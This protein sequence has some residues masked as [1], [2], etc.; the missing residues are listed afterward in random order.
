MIA[1]SASVLA[2]DRLRVEYPLANGT[3]FTA[4]ENASL[5]IQPGEIHALVGE[6]GAGKTTIGNTVMGLLETPGRIAAGSIHIDGK[7]FDPVKGSAAGIV[8]GRDVGAIFQDPMTS[9]N[10]L[11][12]IGSQ[13]MEAMRF[14][15]K[16]DRIAAAARALELLESV[17]I[18][19][20]RRR[21]KAY[22][23]QLSGGQRQR[24]VIAAALSCNPKLLVADEPTT[25]LDVS[26]QA[27]ILKLLRDLGDKRG[28]GILLVT[29]NMGVVAQIAD[30]VT[31]MHRGQVVESGA[32]EEVLRR[33]KAPYAR[34]LI[35][36]VPRIDQRLDRFPV[37]G[38]EGKGR[39]EEARA[40][41]RTIAERSDPSADVEP[42]LSVENLCVDY[43]TTGW[44]PGSRGHRFRAVK[45]VSFTIRSGEVFG[46]VGESGCG[47]TTIANVVSG[48][49]KPTSGRVLYRGQTIAGEGATRRI[50]PL[51]QAIQMIFQDPYSSLN[52]RMRIGLILS[53][54]ILYYRLANSRAEAESDVARL[55]EAVGLESEAGQRFPHA[56]S[57][58]QRQRLSIARALGARPK[59]IVCDEP[60]SSLDVSVQAQIL[61]LLKDLRDATGLTLLLISHDL[62]VVRQM[63]DRVAV[64]RQGQLL[65]EADAATLFDDP[66]HPYTKELLS[67]VPTLDRIRGE[68]QAA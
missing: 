65:E 39:A 68:T 13:L 6:S 63:C 58:G 24:V 28:I 15:L 17:G 11:F 20:P 18:P 3:T 50:G 38:A 44:L 55:I 33:P 67:L 54:P 48:L 23:H 64:M 40:E 26:V 37:L 60:T 32:T 9:L 12:T 43:T 8:L 2:I 45:E 27:Q 59:L 62:A 52:S 1:P 25:A 4:V 41:L 14:H 46:L 7:E 21:L 36:A 5:T 31:I 49:I 56:F 19:E 53:E 10:P 29:H 16:L 42:I 47:K 30:R 66:K 61:N 51:R 34:A 57:G 35:G 22:P